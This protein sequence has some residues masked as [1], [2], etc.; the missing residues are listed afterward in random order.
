MTITQ[1]KLATVAVSALGILLMVP[2]VV[3]L[4]VSW[5]TARWHAAFL[6]A[7]AIVPTLLLL[8]FFALFGKRLWLGCL[9]L[10]PFAAL[11]PTELF[12]V[13]RYG[14]ASSAEILGTV[15]AT[16]PGETIGYFGWVLLPLALC[17]L[18]GLLLALAAAWL[19]YKV[20]LRWSGRIREWLFVG[21]IVLPTMIVVVGMV[22]SKGD[23]HTRLASGLGSLTSLDD[24]VTMG[25]PFGVIRRVW[26]YE[27]EWHAMYANFAKLDDFRFHARQTGEEVK[28]RQ[29]YVMV[30]GESSRRDHWQLFG[31]DRP[32]NPELTQVQN[33][34]RIPDMLS[35]WPQS[36]TAIP[37]LLTRKPVTASG[38]GWKEASILR[39]MQ[40]AGYETWWISNQLPIGR[41]DSP[42]SVYALEAKHQLFLNHA[43][44]AAGNNFDEDLLQPLKDVIAN[45]PT[46]SKIF[47]VLH[48]MGSHAPYDKRYPSTFRRFS[49]TMS[50]AGDKTQQLAGEQNSYDNT[51]LYTDH[52]LAQ[53]IHILRQ[54]DAV[55]ALWFESDHGESLPTATCSLNDHGNGT[56]YEFTIPGLFWYSDAYK[57]L[58]PQRVSQLQVNAEKPA[59]SA[60]TF[61]SLIDMT[62]VDFPGHD[63][64]WSLFSS[65]W[66]YH[67]RI[68]HGLWATD[69]DKA[70]FSAA[71]QMVFPPTVQ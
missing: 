57:S 28:Q 55:S 19:S 7:T 47:I 69:F 2:N 44:W 9:L 48:M 13:A 26:V 23:L 3:L 35:S 16:N 21:A 36:I 62:G 59:L 60:S 4:L 61:E 50:D 63:P 67:P 70:R 43:D 41:Y 6:V 33:L 37:A 71:C 18:I 22:H 29:I 56:R 8:S 53:V 54:S 31:Y 66:T 64:S 42:V 10:T 14:Q 11:A 30:I 34:V 17:M 25:Y 15:S 12:Y 46:K 49:P 52:V 40:E 45:N 24:T 68:V 1:R 58:F 27:E 20:K 39:A 38:F 51:I 32:T 5:D 65:Q